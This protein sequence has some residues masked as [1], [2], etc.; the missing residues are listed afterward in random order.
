MN[1]CAN[2]ARSGNGLWMKPPIVAA[3][4]SPSSFF[5]LDASPKE[6]SSRTQLFGPGDLAV[7]TDYRDV[8]AEVC[9]KRL[10]NPALAEIFPG[11][12][13]TLRGY[14]K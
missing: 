10:K 7:T 6:T 4:E 5:W 11:Y 2:R 12:T 9:V 3:S 13:A 1:A 14:L 8:L